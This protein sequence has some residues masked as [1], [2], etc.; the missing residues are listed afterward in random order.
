[1]LLPQ[2]GGPHDRVDVAGVE[3]DR[4]A[5]EHVHAILVL[6]EK[7]VQFVALEDDFSIFVGSMASPKVQSRAD[8][9]KRKE[10]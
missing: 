2:P 4:H 10:C 7:A 9:L 3:L 5:V 6:A 1:M 8:K